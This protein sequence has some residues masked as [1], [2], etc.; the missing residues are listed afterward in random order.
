PL[1]HT[2]P[3]RTGLG[4]QAEGKH[5]RRRLQRLRHLGPSAP[6]HEPFGNRAASRPLCGTVGGGGGTRGSTG[7]RRPGGTVRSGERPGPAGPGARPGPITRL[8]EIK[9]RDTSSLKEKK[10]NQSGK[11]CRYS[12]FPHVENQRAFS[13]S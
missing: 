6:P 8:I 13:L 12:D 3:L 4:L 11:I 1:D 9:L 2:P 7:S 5:A 10:A